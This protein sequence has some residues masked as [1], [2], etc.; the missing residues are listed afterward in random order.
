MKKNPS[1]EISILDCT[2]RDGSYEIDYRFTA[3]QTVLLCSSLEEAGIRDIEIGHG[4]GFHASECGNGK[5]AATDEEYLEAAASTLRKARFGM[6]WIPG[7]ARI[8]DLELGAKYGMGF[9]RIGSNVTETEKTREA[10]SRAKELGLE[11][12]ANFMKTYA[13]SPKEF[14]KAA[15]MSADFGSDVLCVVDSAGGMYPDE[16]AEYV[17]VALAETGKRI[18]FHGHNNLALAIA[19]TLAAADAGA[20]LV[21]STLLGLGRSAGNAQTETLAMILEQ[22]GYCTGAD[23]Y[24]LMDLAECVL[25]PMTNTSKGIASLDIAIGAGL[26]HSSFLK[27]VEKVAAETGLDARRLVVA[28]KEKEIVKVTEAIVRE[29]A[30]R[31]LES[32]SA[33]VSDA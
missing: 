33:K 1:K 14:A 2:L 29:V 24:A 12:S 8:A 18:G 13:V 22:R 30:E 11:V 9:V 15:K 3:E 23:V 6:F 28:L 26:F 19:N 4:L 7:I 20:S 10:V 16:V 32:Q 31:M 27:H 5:A 25:R 21:D 17:R